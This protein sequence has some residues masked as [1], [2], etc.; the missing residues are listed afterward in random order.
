M[1]LYVQNSD[2]SDVNLLL[3]ESHKAKD[4]L[5]S[6]KQTFQRHVGVSLISGIADVSINIYV[7]FHMYF[8]VSE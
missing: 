5:R 7:Y 2:S 3:Q 1:F 4:L 8:E 6:I